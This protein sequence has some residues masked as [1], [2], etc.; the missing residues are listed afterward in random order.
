M[1]WGGG[2]G[3][4]ASLQPATRHAAA[5]TNRRIARRVFTIKGTVLLLQIL[6]IGD[7][8]GR[9]RQ[10]CGKNC[11]YVGSVRKPL[12]VNVYLTDNV[13]ISILDEVIAWKGSRIF[14]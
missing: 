4:G 3:G 11:G 5:Q 10:D 2:G 7:Y 8:G 9:C 12:Q 6:K 14:N 13:R 1:A